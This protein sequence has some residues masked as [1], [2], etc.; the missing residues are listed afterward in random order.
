VT[1]IRVNG[2][3]PG[4]NDACT[5][6][7]NTV[8]AVVKNQGTGA[9]GGFTVR[10]IVDDASHAAVIESVGA[11]DVGNQRE[12]RFGGVE[13]K[14]GERT[15][16]VRADAEQAVPESNEG[17]NDRTVSATCKDDD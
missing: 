3:Q 16:A 13:L 5:S 10:L 12:I 14:K 17:N 6:G 8:T 11:L 9:A 4:A 1:A 15:L 2:K 7:K